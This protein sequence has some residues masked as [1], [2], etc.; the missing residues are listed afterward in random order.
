[1]IAAAQKRIRLIGRVFAETGI[2]DLFLNVHELLRLHGREV[3]AS[4]GGKWAKVD[5]ST[6]PQ[7]KGL[8]VEIGVGSGGREHD[9]MAGNALLGMIQNAVTGQGGLD[10]PLINAEGIRTAVRRQTERL[11][12]KNAEQYWPD[13]P[14]PGPPQPPP[15]DPKLV[16]VQQK[17]QLAQ[18]QAQQAHELAVKKADADASLA[19]QESAQRLTLAAQD[20]ERAHGLKVQTADA[21]LGLKRELLQAELDMK[22][23][24]MVEETRLKAAGVAV[25]RYI[26]TGID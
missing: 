26:N 20:A 15:P 25:D 10:G 19:Q 2:K 5:P 22:R 18:M 11:G 8:K 6:W 3:M 14:E 7:R 1:L 21:E 12:F 13:P 16:E 23:Q 17:G 4:V 24:Q 9:I